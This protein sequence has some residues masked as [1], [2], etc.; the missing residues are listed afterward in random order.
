MSEKAFIYRVDGTAELVE[1]EVGKSLS[2]LQSAVEGYIECVRLTDTL[3]M[4]VNENFIAENLSLN[5]LGSIF[6]K[7]NFDK[8]M[9]ILGNIIFTGGADD[10]GETLGLNARE[11]DYLF[12][13]AKTAEPV[14]RAWE[15]HK[16]ER[17]IVE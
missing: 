13:C 2:V 5:I 12:A 14:L 1:F 7:E 6:Y 3:E 16:A 8:D 11:I 17:G 15:A 4:W 9:P 10:E